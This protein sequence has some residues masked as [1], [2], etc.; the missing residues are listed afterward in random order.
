MRWHVVH[1]RLTDWAGSEAV[2]QS[3]ASALSAGVLHTL[4]HDTRSVSPNRLPG[5]ELRTSPLQR[6]PGPLRTRRSLFP[7]WPWAIERLD[8]SDA[9][10]VLSSHHAVAKG[11]RTRADQPHVCYVH[12][13]ARWAWDLADEEQR[14][15]NHGR[16]K[17]AVTSR[18]LERFRH[19]DAGCANRVDLYL[20]N[21]TTVAQRIERWYRRPSKVIAPPVRVVFFRHDPAVERGDHYL[22]AGRLVPYKRTADAIDACGRLGRTLRVV[23]DGPLAQ[24]L[25][26]QA[27]GAKI[28]FV[29]PVSDERF[30]DE[31]RRCRALLMPQH[32]DFGIVTVEAMA[33]GA[34]VIALGQGGAL[35]TVI[36][37]RTGVLYPNPGQA[38]LAQAI[39]TFEADPDRFDP[40]VLHKHAQTFDTPVFQAALSSVAQ[41]FARFF[42][43]QGP[44]PTLDQRVLDEFRDRA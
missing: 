4:V 5:V 13:P 26:R 34:P 2:A 19:W 39:R 16:V 25:R 12:S 40:L 18:L 33:T 23:G 10:A 42:A 32:E 36:P 43:E 1:E 44:S 20:A 11:V 24:T 17:R 15:R 7:L 27:R 29:G 31:L 28:D 30:A 9:D 37:D 14:L 22:V 8:V 3:A 21:S 35:D 38:G 41:R 6:L